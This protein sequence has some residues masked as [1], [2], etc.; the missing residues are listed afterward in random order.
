MCVMEVLGLPNLKEE[1]GSELQ[2][3]GNSLCAPKI[4]EGLLICSELWK[5][6]RPLH[7]RGKAGRDLQKWLKLNFLDAL[8][9]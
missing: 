5:T 8:Q 2:A 6:K 3:S 7:D 4:V 1:A 9:G